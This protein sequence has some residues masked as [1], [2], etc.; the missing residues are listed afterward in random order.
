MKKN[1]VKLNVVLQIIYEVL[2]IVVSLITTPYVARVLGPE[3]I[4]DNAFAVSVA[5]VFCLFLMLGLKSYGSKCISISENKNEVFSQLILLHLLISL[6][7]IGLY[8][9]FIFSFY[10]SYRILFYI[11]YM[12]LIASTLDVN[13]VYIG[14]GK[15]NVTVTKNIIFRILS[16]I[17]IFVLVKASKDLYIYA[18]ILGGTNVIGNLY[19]WFIVFKEVKIVKIQISS[20]KKH[21]IPLLKM[22]VPILALSI[23]RYTDTIMIRIFSTS[24]QVG[25][26]NQTEKIVDLG[27]AVVAAIG[28][29]M[30][31]YSSKLFYKNDFDA[32]VKSI[33][34]TN[35]FSA[36]LSCAL[37]FGFCAM[38][39]Y[40]CLVYL[41]DSF[42]GAIMLLRFLP[43]TL[44][45]M[46]FSNL[47]RSQ[48]LIPLNK[49]RVYLIAIF[50]G[51]I[52]NIVSNIFFIKFY[53][54]FGA[55]ITTLI[56]EFIV[57]TIQNIFVFKELKIGKMMLDY[58]PFIIIGLVMY[59]S[60]YFLGN[61]FDYS[62]INMFILLIVGAIIYVILSIVYLFF[63]RKNY[64]KTLL[65]KEPN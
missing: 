59:L 63:F 14:L 4:G 8:T 23:Y 56:T 53:G 47:I 15:I 2:I 48:Y 17:A 64:I 29:V 10:S 11:G 9:I 43:L 26:Y 51:L 50:L 54:A 28:T 62:W 16:I 49:D 5:N 19:L 57:M 32:G 34:A 40:I 58:I 60:L 45:F 41:G 36:F 30:L 37:A 21:I 31:P 38:S 55:V 52:I 20:L 24:E 42:E 44:I 6:I 46:C 39:E 25:F 22:F 3:L 13:W 1:N 65:K 27:Y 7:V 33:F 61:F 35:L 12:Y 18:I